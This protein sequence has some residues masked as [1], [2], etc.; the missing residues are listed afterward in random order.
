MRRWVASFFVVLKQFSPGGANEQMALLQG[1]ENP[2]C[3]ANV[4]AAQIDLIRWRESIRRMMELK[5]PSPPIIRTYVA[6][7][8][9]FSGVFEKADPQLNLR[10]VSLKNQ[11]GLPHHKNPTIITN[12]LV[13][14]VN[15]SRIK[16][17]P[18]RC[19]SN[20]KAILFF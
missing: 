11:L 7:E 9:I 14:L 18:R 13:A 6:T 15:R 17:P 12:R 3:C 20:L 2:K 10:W 16:P 19:K 8:S 4:K 5:L 1:L